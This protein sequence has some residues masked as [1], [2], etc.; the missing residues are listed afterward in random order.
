MDALEIYSQLQPL[1]LIVKDRISTEALRLLKEFATIRQQQKW[2]ELDVSESAVDSFR[3]RRADYPVLLLELGDGLM[4]AGR[5]PQAADCFAEAEGILQSEMTPGDQQNKAVAALY[6]GLVHHYLDRI[7]DAVLAF[8]EARCQFKQAI[9]D[10]HAQAKSDARAEECQLADDQLA[11]C[12]RELLLIRTSTASPGQPP[13]AGWV[14]VDAVDPLPEPQFSQPA[15]ATLGCELGVLGVAVTVLL[16]VIL[17]LV[18]HSFFGLIGLLAFAGAWFSVIVTV[19]LV[20]RASSGG[21]FRLR[22]PY[23]HASVVD[24][25]GQIHVIGP[26][27]SWV[28]IPGLRK[29]RATVPLMRLTH[30]LKKHIVSIR[31][32]VGGEST[33]RLRVTVQIGYQVADVEL[34]ALRFEEALADVRGPKTHADLQGVWQ[35]RLVSDLKP[36]LVNELWAHPASECLAHRDKIQGN[37][38]HRLAK[39]THEWGVNITD[40]DILDMEPQ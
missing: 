36:L 31:G 21:L 9:D 40:L 15:G 25:V 12:V 23:E 4:R 20:A 38:R 8:G 14:D 5:I 10:W 7:A 29:L 30:T 28:L 34:A 22:V 39:K 17:A 6:R 24:E 13:S 37:L 11:N 19:L 1:T 35:S 32:T 27:E 18:V 16:T 33:A 2:D 26:G 3:H